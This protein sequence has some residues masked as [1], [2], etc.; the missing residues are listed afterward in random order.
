M[1]SHKYVP[2]ITLPTRIV[3]DP[4]RVSAT[5]I[6]HIFIK[7]PIQDV[8]TDVLSGMIFCDISDH[9]PCFVS[10]KTDIGVSSKARPMTRLY[11]KTNC[12]KF[13]NEMY[14]TSW[15][16]V[17][18][19][20][21][22]WYTQFVLKI[23]CIFEASFPLVC[24][25]RKRSH[26]KPWINAGLK[27]CIRHNHHLYKKSITRPTKQRTLIYKQYNATLKRCVEASRCKYYHDLF[28]NNKNAAYNLWKNLGTVLNPNKKRKSNIIDK[29]FV[30]G[31]VVTDKKEIPTVLNKYFCNIG[32]NLQREL[33]VNDDDDSFK[34]Y[35][36][37]PRIDS[38]Y[39]RPTTTDEILLEIQKLNPKKATGPDGISAKILQLCPEIFAV[40]LTKIYNKAIANA[41]YPTLMKISKVI[42]LFKKGEKHN[43]GNYRPIS[44]LSCFNKILEKIVC[45]QLTKYLELKN[46]LFTFQFGFRK[47]YSTSLALTET[48]DSIRRLI[49]E[50]NYVLGIFVD[51]TKAFDTVDHEILLYKMGVYGVRGHAN[52]FFR[53]YLSNRSQ[54]TLVNGFESPASIIKCGVPQGSVLG[55]ILFL[56][57]INDLYLAINQG[58]ARLF[59]D[60]TGIFVHSKNF[61]TLIDAAKRELSALCEWCKSNKLTINSS[62]TC[63]VIFH[64]KNKY[65]H[66]DC[67]E[68]VIP[69]MTIK[70]VK[71]TKY[72]GLIFDEMLTWN[73]HVKQLSG[74]L[75]KYF[76][77]FNHVKALMTTQT[78]RQ[79]YF[80][81]IYSRISYGIEVYGNC[82]VKT[83]QKI[84]VLQN[85]LLKLILRKDSR[86]PTNDL[87]QEL[88]LLKVKDIQKMKILCFVNNCLLGSC[89]P[90]FN[91]YFVERDNVYNFRRSHLLAPRTRTELGSLSIKVQGCRLWNGLPESVKAFRYQQNFKKYI[92]KHILQYA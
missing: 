45:K 11:G 7:Y 82:T 61:G 66:P 60:D 70:R 83:L 5:C 44:L 50:K 31:K 92:V 1:L 21:L 19:D 88:H 26:D 9:L 72:L 63:F 3:S 38:F 17:F 13:I 86:T 6:D 37:A 41:E 25:S 22:D 14:T 16:E 10:I 30:N 79:L 51:L 71:N 29:L 64:S 55:P 42:S 74:S 24:V 27:K 69:A 33:N 91:N 52:K 40:N 15:D 75:L 87:H 77:I 65:A 34:R 62:K 57:Y 4:T 58:L 47:G 20:D 46:I 89:A 28:D 78:A 73:E 48:T 53:S 2:Y 18:V 76:G 54:Y 59:A 12:A 39:L 32:K 56:I 49:D 35:L 23:K 67:Q 36:P 43:P 85:K 8:R 90:S 80:S 81:F 68:L 84:Q